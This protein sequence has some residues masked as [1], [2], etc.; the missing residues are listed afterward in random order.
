[1]VVTEI[2]QAAAR[3]AAFSERR[4]GKRSWANGTKG[5]SINRTDRIESRMMA[6]S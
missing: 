2:S 1:L 4:I 5:A 6:V 3:D